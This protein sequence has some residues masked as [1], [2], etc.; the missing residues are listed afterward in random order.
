[1]DKPLE[2]LLAQFLAWVAAGPRTHADAMEAWRTS[3]PR[4]PAWEEALDA[5]FITC[6]GVGDAPVRLTPRGAAWL[7]AHG[8]P[9]C[10]AAAAAV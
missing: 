3:C 6:A 2:H 8:S 5:G 7:A 10:A 9:G 4:L 1:M